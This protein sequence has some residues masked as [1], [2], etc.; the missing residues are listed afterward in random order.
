MSVEEADSYHLAL[1]QVTA[2][3]TLAE[4]QAIAHLALR[5]WRAS[6]PADGEPPPAPVQSGA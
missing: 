5:R 2:A 6:A 3:A 1:A 4:A